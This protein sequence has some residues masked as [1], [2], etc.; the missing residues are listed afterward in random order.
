MIAYLAGL[1]EDDE[2]QTNDLDGLALRLKRIGERWL[3]KTG[4]G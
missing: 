1:A 3:W 4:Q 2:Q